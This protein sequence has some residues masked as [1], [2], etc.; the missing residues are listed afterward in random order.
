MLSE[1]NETP[2]DDDYDMELPE[3]ADA[4]QIKM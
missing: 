2:V 4:K 3:W 1:G